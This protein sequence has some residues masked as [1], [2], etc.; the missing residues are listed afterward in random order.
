MVTFSSANAILMV[1]AVRLANPG[2]GPMGEEPDR[3]AFA[4]PGLEESGIS[5][6]VSALIR[7]V[8]VSG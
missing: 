7:G 4:L 5:P 6:L 3:R 2:D 1:F 8:L